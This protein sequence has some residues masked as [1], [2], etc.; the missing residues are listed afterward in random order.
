MMI[1]LY[2]RGI[3]RIGTSMRMVMMGMKMNRGMNILKI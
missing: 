1:G 3:V 2:W